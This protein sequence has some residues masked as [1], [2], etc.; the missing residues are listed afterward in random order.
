MTREWHVWEPIISLENCRKAVLCEACTPRCG[1]NGFAADLREHDTQWANYVRDRIGDGLR[2]GAFEEFDVWESG[3]LRHVRC[4]HPKDAMCVRACV[5]VMEPLAYKRMTPRSYCPVPGRG[6]LKLARDFRRSLRHTEN[7]CRVWNKY[8]PN[9]KTQWRTWIEMFDEQH[10][11]DS[12]TYNVMHDTMFRIFGEPEI[13][14][15]I[16][17]FLGFRDGLP[18]GAGYSSMVANMVLAPLDWEIIRTPGVFGYARHLDNAALITKSKKAATDV[19]HLVEDWNAQRGLVAHEWAKFPAGHH[20]VERGGWRIDADRIL[21]S[22][23]VT[24]HIE[25]LL[26]REIEKLSHEEHLALASLWGY[27]KHGES[28]SLK[29]LWRERKAWRVF[30]LVGASAKDAELGIILDN[31]PTKRKTP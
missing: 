15:I 22:T 10:F 3:K 26:S 2:L 24:R 14:A 4:Y 31:K 11:Y 1:R 13:H 18:I 28:E 17:E 20:A 16:E 6:G 8:H 29:R 19:R 12:L 7:R 5:Q 23:N 25:R 27:V 9:A 21:P 30:K